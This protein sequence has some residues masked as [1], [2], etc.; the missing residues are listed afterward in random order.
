MLWIYA[1]HYFYSI[2]IGGRACFLIDAVL[3]SVIAFFPQQEE[4][5]ERNKRRNKAVVFMRGSWGLGG[6]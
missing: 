3:M 6:M 1:T 4:E 2:Y 5:E